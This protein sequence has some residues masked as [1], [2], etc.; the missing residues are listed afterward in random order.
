MISDEQAAKHRMSLTRSGRKGDFGGELLTVNFGPQHPSTH[1]VLRLIVDLDGELIRRVE[2]V[3]GYL[4]TGIEKQAES[5]RYQQ[6]VVVTDRHDYLAPL[7]NNL[8]YA[9]AVERLMGVEAPARAQVLR[10]I[11]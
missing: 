7:N 4:H 11:M 9:L 10:V 5:L 8:A 3:I 2:P 6:V 1:G